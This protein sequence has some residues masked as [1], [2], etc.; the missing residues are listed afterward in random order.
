MIVV[1]LLDAVDSLQ[2]TASASAHGR[3]NKA[4]AGL[5]PTVFPS[6]L[7]NLV[8]VRITDFPCLNRKLVVLWDSSRAKKPAKPPRFNNCPPH[9]VLKNPKFIS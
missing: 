7:Q 8:A 6:R 1:V 3:L 5:D 4:K 2:Y 9:T